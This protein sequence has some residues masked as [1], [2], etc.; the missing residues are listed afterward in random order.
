MPKKSADCFKDR[1]VLGEGH[2]WAMGLS[3]YHEIA[4]GVTGMLGEKVELDF[5]E[6]L[7]AKDVPRYR[8]VLE[9]VEPEEDTDG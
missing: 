8:L 3:S 6:E 7:W 5:P 9:R 4:L 2:P 1:Y